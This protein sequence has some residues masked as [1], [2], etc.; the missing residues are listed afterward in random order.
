MGLFSRKKCQ[1]HK[2]EYSIGKDGMSQPFYYCKKCQ[3][4]MKRIRLI[5]EELTRSS[6]VPGMGKTRFDPNW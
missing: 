1:V 5:E 2:I 3:K 6:N 4:E